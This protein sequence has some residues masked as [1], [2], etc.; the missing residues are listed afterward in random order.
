MSGVSNS[1]YRDGIE[2]DSEGTVVELLEEIA[3]K[4]PGAI[5]EYLKKEIKYAAQEYFRVSQAWQEFVCL[6]TLTESLMPYNMTPVDDTNKK[7][8]AILGMSREG[9]PYTRGAVDQYT[10]MRNQ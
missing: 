5:S 1:E 10:A 7:V 8:Y 3:P 9:T 6:P 2:D 4:V